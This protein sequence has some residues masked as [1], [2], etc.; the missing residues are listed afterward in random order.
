MGPGIFF[1]SLPGSNSTNLELIPG[2]LGGGQKMERF[3]THSVPLD[4]LLHS[5]PLTGVRQFFRLFHFGGFPNGS[6][7]LFRIRPLNL[8]PQVEGIWTIT[9]SLSPFSLYHNLGNLQWLICDIL[10]YTGFP[11]EMNLVP[12]RRLG[13]ISGLPLIGVLPH[14]HFRTRK[15][16]PTLWG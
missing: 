10:F 3:S 2:F 4:F 6:S 15:F 12:T 14:S 8:I 13:L 11:C 9:P 1:I 5:S 7:F 16:L